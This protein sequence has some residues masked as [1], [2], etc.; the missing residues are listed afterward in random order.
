[1]GRT[2]GTKRIGQKYIQLRRKKKNLLHGTTWNTVVYVGGRLTI[3]PILN[4]DIGE[5]G[6]DCSG[7]GYGPA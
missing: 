5:N 6:L 7:L 4:K 1:M 2:C 3:K